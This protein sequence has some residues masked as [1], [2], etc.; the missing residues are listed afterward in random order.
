MAHF[1]LII[2]NGLHPSARV[3]STWIKWDSTG[4][5]LSQAIAQILPSGWGKTESI[6]P[7]PLCWHLLAKMRYCSQRVQQDREMSA[8]KNSSHLVD[9]DSTT[10]MVYI[11][12]H[13]VDRTDI[14][15]PAAL[16]KHF[17]ENMAH[18][19]SVR[20]GLKWS[21]TKLWLENGESFQESCLN[22]KIK[23]L[24]CH[25]WYIQHFCNSWSEHIYLIML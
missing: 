16:L 22:C 21:D 14:V 1:F 11:S 9:W 10:F 15:V 7:N 20:R 24:L 18:G 4:G 25:V 2:L 17:G 23:F 3:A 6:R 8:S 13:G 19:L 5:R 12:R